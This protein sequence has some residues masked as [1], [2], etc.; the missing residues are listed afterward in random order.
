MIYTSQSL[1]N[2][3]F[4]FSMR[5]GFRCA[6]RFEKPFI[7][8]GAAAILADIVTV[9]SVWASLEEYFGYTVKITTYLANPF[10]YGLAV[11]SMAILVYLGLFMVLAYIIGVS[12]IRM[13]KRY[14]FH[15][16]EERFQ[17][18][19]KGKKGETYV[20]VYED[21]MGVSVRERSFPLAAGGLDIIITLRNGRKHLF[22]LVH[23]SDTRAGGV[24]GCPFNIIRERAELLSPHDFNV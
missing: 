18:T 14:E 10:G 24:V 11:L 5:G 16:N 8:I 2:E 13:G 6:Y 22:K 4:G 15:A 19:G 7:I 17:I 23:T 12:I 1:N 21:V 20:I 3:R 9:L